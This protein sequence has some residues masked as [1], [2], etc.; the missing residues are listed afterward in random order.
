VAVA[1]TDAQV[2]KY[3]NRILMERYIINELRAFRADER[4]A[5]LEREA[6]AVFTAGL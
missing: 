2:G 6:R 1:A 3:I 4:R 5:W